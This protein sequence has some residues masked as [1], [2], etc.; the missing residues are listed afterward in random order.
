MYGSRMPDRSTLERGMLHCTGFAIVTNA[1]NVC[2]EYTGSNILLP[3]ET[4]PDEMLF[5]QRYQQQQQQHQF[6]IEHFSS[7]RLSPR[8][9]NETGGPLDSEDPLESFA[10]YAQQKPFKPEAAISPSEHDYNYGEEQ[11]GLDPATVDTVSDSSFGCQG[12]EG[13]A[14]CAPYDIGEKLMEYPPPDGR[15]ANTPAFVN[16][17]ASYRP[18]SFCGFLPTTGGNTSTTSSTTRGSSSNSNNSNSCTNSPAPENFLDNVF[19]FT[20]EPGYQLPAES[21]KPECARIKALEAEFA[22]SQ[23][24]TRLRRYE[25]AVALCLSERQVKVMYRGSRIDVAKVL[26]MRLLC[27]SHIPLL[28]FCCG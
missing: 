24:L 18:A 6:H 2:T 10:S 5:Y 22:H 7:T 14:R 16:Y 9:P 21:L 28:C 8:V 3:R 13:Y 27:R 12:I 19:P 15:F 11:R 4:T 26:T 25:I 17:V 1:S 20:C 23:Y